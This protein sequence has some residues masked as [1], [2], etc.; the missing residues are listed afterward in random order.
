MSSYLT[1]FLV[2][3]KSKKRYKDGAEEEI[4]LTQEPLALCSFCRSSDIYQVIS[5]ELNPAYA[6]NYDKYSEITYLDIKNVCDTYKNEHIETTKRR[7]ETLYKIVRATA[8]SDIIDD[9]MNTEEYLRDC[10]FIL[11]KLKALRDIIYEVYEGYGD[12]EKVLINID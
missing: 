3:K 4:K 10:E 1:F 11:E 2:P 12:F 7:L 9:I 6:G 5:E 8:D